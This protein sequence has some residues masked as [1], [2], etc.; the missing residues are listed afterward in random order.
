MTDETGFQNWLDAHP[1]DAVARMAFADYLEEIGDERAE[2]Y[3]ELGRLGKRPFN[4]YGSGKSYC[5]HN[6][7][8]RV[9]NQPM[10]EYCRLDPEWLSL[11]EMLE[12]GESKQNPHTILTC[13][14]SSRRIVEDA[15][16]RAYARLLEKRKQE[17]SLVGGVV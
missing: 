5:Y 8:G 1:D 12:S 14:N 4:G 11:T 9:G 16:S 17:S 7:G 10:P 2:G 6:G 13:C 3:R 15:A